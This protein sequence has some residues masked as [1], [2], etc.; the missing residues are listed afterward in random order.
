MHPSDMLHPFHPRDPEVLPGTTPS[1]LPCITVVVVVV[2]VVI[3][4]VAV[5]V[6]YCNMDRT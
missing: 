1:E 5:I 3:V 4:G 2:V 6:V